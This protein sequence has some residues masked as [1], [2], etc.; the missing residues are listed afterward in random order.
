[1]A[2]KYLPKRTTGVG[3][4]DPSFLARGDTEQY[5]DGAKTFRNVRQ[6]NSGAW[7]RRPGSLWL[8]TLMASSILVDFNFDP[9]QKYV[10]AFSNTRMDAYLDDGSAAGN[11]TS[12]PWTTAILNDLRWLVEGDT[13]FLCEQSMQT[14]VIKRTGASSWSRAA[15]AFDGG[16][17]STVAQP[18]YKFAANDVTLQPGG[19]TG[20][21]SLTTSASFFVND[22]IGT[23]IRFLGR[24]I[25]I[26]GVTNGTT[27]TGT[28]QETLPRGHRLTVA[29]STKFQVG[30][31]VEHSVDGTKGIVFAIP[32]TTEV[33]VIASEGIEIFPNSG[34]L[35][36]PDGQSAISGATYTAS[37]PALTNWDEQVFSDVRGYPGV[38]GLHKNRL[39]FADHPEIPDM[40]FMSV[41]GQYFN[42]EL[43]TGNDSDAIIEP[44]GNGR[45]KRVRG[46]V[47]GENLF[48][49]TDN[50][51]Y[52]VP[53]SVGTPIT[54]ETISF[55]RIGDSKA[56]DAP[57]GFFS[58]GVHYPDRS[59]KRITRVRATGNNTSPW[60]AV[61]NSLISSHLINSPVSAA[62]ANEF[63]EEP[64]KYGFFVNAD[65]TLAVNHNIEDQSVNGYTLWETDGLYKSVCVLDNEVFVCVEREI[66]SSTIYTLEKFDPDLRVD[67]AK[68]FTGTTPTIADYANHPVR[69]T[70]STYDFGDY[71]PD[72]SGNFEVE[73]ASYSSNFEAGLFYAPDVK[74]LPYEIVGDESIAGLKKKYTKIWARVKDSGRYSVNGRFTTAYRGGD[75]L[76]QPPPLR[77]EQKRFSSLG[78][79]LDPTIDFSQEDCVPLTV[80]GVTAEVSF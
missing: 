24:E 72:G 45:V 55:R 65:G 23:R 14:Q 54:A 60:E 26:T 10:L 53:E 40:I 59:G 25:L 56:G 4:V 58:N 11:L 27:A 69:V 17:G 61:D 21:I 20:S 46:I 75:D 64:E 16:V 6:L 38:V 19:Y 28:V 50:G 47:S 78:R 63:Y 7:T 30:H 57:A 9:S 42:F 49:L 13:V 29:D 3:E 52:F 43:G 71:T 39:I 67:C 34:I 37:Q 48:I 80:L 18:Y 1:M 12:A 8:L 33:D 62:Y 76:T 5:R 41:A 66:D 22:H 32:S 77:T 44:I 36:S 31:V 35:I 2:K 15:F 70:G 74:Y 73:T 79:S 51:P 68:T